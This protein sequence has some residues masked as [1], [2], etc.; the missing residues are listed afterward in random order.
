[1]GGGGLRIINQV[2]CR[3]VVTPNELITRVGRQKKRHN[4]G[5]K[6]VN[7]KNTT[8]AVQ[9]ELQRQ[10][11]PWATRVSRHLR[12]L[13]LLFQTHPITITMRNNLS[14]AVLDVKSVIIMLSKMRSVIRRHNLLNTDPSSHLFPALSTWPLHAHQQHLSTNPQPRLFLPQHTHTRATNATET[15]QQ[16]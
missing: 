1:M 10:Q 6:A 16:F 11:Q 7:I 8:S 13:S 4:V 12:H 5:W 9:F 3:F 14:Q 2:R 15:A